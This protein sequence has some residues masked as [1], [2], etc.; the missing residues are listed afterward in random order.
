MV[1][2][3]LALVP[4]P[5]VVSMLTVLF[6]TVVTLASPGPDP[7]QLLASVKAYEEA[8]N[9]HDWS[10]AVA[11]IDDEAVVGLGGD[12]T[13]VGRESVR[14][15]HEWEGVLTTEIHYS[16][17]AVADRTVTCRASEQNDFLRLARLGPVEYVSASFTFERGRIVRMTA[18]LS[19]ESDRAVS[20]YMQDFLA[21]AGRAEPKATGSFLNVDGSFAFGVDPATTFKR[22]L[23]VYALTKGGAARAL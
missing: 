14:A 10:K 20:G 4:A 1:V 23:K 12:L 9:R 11:L 19:E 3:G 15:L 21:W 22:L 7:S 2:F 17:C 16:D 13:L 5:G 6:A 18:E 8:A